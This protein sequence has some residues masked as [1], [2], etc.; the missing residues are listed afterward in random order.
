MLQTVEITHP[1]IFKNAGRHFRA[2]LDLAEVAAHSFISAKR[3]SV[4]M[5][6]F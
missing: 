2:F 5:L 1:Y 6:R 3:R 4:F